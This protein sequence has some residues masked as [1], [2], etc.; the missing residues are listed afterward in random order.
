MRGRVGHVR[1]AL[2]RQL[3]PL[4]RA[5]ELSVR[6]GEG[7]TRTFPLF[8]VFTKRDVHQFSRSELWRIVQEVFA[9]QLARL[10]HRVRLRIHAVQS[11]GFGVDLESLLR[12]EARSEGIGLFLADVHRSI[13]RM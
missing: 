4:T 2:S 3:V 10:E 8:L 9:I 5:I 1:E 12:L 11:I 7:R 6:R 13:E